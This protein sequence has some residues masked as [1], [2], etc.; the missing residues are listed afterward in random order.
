MSA[1][2]L[3]R[4]LGLAAVGLGALGQASPSPTAL[5][6][7]GRWIAA[8]ADGVALRIT[9]DADAVRLDFDFQGHG[10]WAAARLP[11]ALDL[12]ENWALSFELRGEAPANHLEVKLVDPSLESVWWSVRRDYEWPRQWTPMRIKKRQVRFAWGPARGGEIRRLGALELAITAGSGGRGT[13]WLRNVALTALPP[14]A[15]YSGTPTARASAEV[16]GHG[17]A[18]ALDGDHATFWQAPPGPAVW[19]VDFG[20]PRELGGLTLR[21]RDGGQPPG[22]A[23][24][25][26]HDGARY[27]LA[28]EIGR[29]GGGR[30]DLALPDEEARF[31]RIAVPPGP[32]AP[33][34]AEL[35]VRPLGFAEDANAIF[36]AVAREAPRGDY[37]RGFS[38]EQVYWTVV[39]LDGAE[40]EVL[41]S[42]DGGVELGVSAPALEPFLSVDGRFAS[43]SDVTAA[44]RLLD[45]DLPI[46]SVDWELGGIRLEI[47]ALVAPQGEGSLL[48]V[49]YRLLNLDAR[50]HR[51]TLWLAAR[52]FQVNP[53]AQ[54]LNAQGGVARLA[55][56]RCAPSGL[57]LDRRTV[58]FAPAAQRCG[59]A[60]FDQGSIVAWLR[61][62]EA[63]PDTASRD[64]LAL[65]SAAAAWD[66]ELAPGA[67]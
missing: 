33:A 41:V 40:S 27:R 16:R 56:V 67:S 63:P 6:D 62:G 12:P 17:A 20:V 37:P 35:V 21:W 3:A 53:P 54:F 45:G 2:V 60:V 49:R 14:D 44:Q 5:A 13:V 15:P 11:L 7:A 29:A 36:E 19:T 4:L 18:A 43:W 66:F 59:T 23:V 46:P 24:E 51:A 28:R 8:P 58:A 39:G 50:A 26:S 57:A 47:T 25:L 31:V 48:L 9:P 42:E 52:P 38:G 34:L 32:V 10:G 1:R 55:D 61:R 64:E 65:A 30:N 22:F